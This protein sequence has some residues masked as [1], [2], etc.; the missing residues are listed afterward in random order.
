MASE[1]LPEE[2][3]KA[4][5]QTISNARGPSTLTTFNHKWRE[6][7]E[8]CQSRRQD[9]STCSI[10]LGL[11]FLLL[12]LD[13]VRASSTIMLL[14]SSHVL[15]PR[16]ASTRQWEECQLGDIPWYLSSLRVHNPR[17]QSRHLPLVLRSLT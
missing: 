9:P 10:H 14:H 15:L 12:L 3:E 6:L 2:L 8:W 7:S 13:L 17:N 1:L 11:C 4:V 16:L 5:M